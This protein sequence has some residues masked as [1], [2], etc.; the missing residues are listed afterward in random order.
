VS[1]SLDLTGLVL[2]NDLYDSQKYCSTVELCGVTVQLLQGCEGIIIIIII[3][4]QN[5][6][7]SFP[8]SAEIFNG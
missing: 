5:K 7:F 1:L 6:T 3:R 2:L 4:R 8:I